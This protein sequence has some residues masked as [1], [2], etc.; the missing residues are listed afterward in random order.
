MINNDKLSDL[1]LYFVVCENIQKKYI[2]KCP[3]PMKYVP[4]PVTCSCGVSKSS[5]DML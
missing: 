2:K 3:V 1:R 4:V 5:E